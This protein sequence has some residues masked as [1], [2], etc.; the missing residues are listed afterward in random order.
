[1]ALRRALTASGSF[2]NQSQNLYNP[3]PIAERSPTTAFGPSP[4][5]IKDRGWYVVPD[6][7]PA[8]P[9][10]GAGFHGFH[11]SEDFPKILL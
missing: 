9:S 6:R 1:M 11:R 8:T 3:R 2:N 7:K 4:L 10:N 5:T